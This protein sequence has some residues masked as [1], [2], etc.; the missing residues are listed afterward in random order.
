LRK[1]LFRA[2][3]RAVIFLFRHPQGNVP[4]TSRNT[5]TI[6]SIDRLARQSLRSRLKSQLNPGTLP[7]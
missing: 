3:T 2:G 1:A 5:G 7:S 4:W 6:A